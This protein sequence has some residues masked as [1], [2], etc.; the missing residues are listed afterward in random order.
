VYSVHSPFC[1]QGDPKKM[2]D[3]IKKLN[4][5]KHFVYSYVLLNF[6]LKTLITILRGHPGVC[7]LQTVLEDEWVLWV[8]I[9]LEYVKRKGKEV[10]KKEKG[11]WKSE[12]QRKWEREEGR[13]EVR[14]WEK[15]E[16][17]K[18]KKK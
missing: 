8:R 1:I 14:K 16:L 10:K 7:A 13:E 5:L 11:K 4:I 6:K 3:S 15:E 18:Y 9:L 2:V 17:I 12:K